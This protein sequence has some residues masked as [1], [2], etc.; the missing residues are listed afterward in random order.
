[1]RITWSASAAA[2]EA[3][4]IPR[5]SWATVS[6]V[7]ASTPRAAMRRQRVSADG[8]PRAAARSVPSAGRAVGAGVTPGTGAGGAAGFGVGAGAAAVA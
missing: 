6:A 3:A 5:T 7:K 2:R 4:F 8:M 1:M